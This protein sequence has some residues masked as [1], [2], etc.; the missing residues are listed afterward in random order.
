[1]EGW[2]S[3]RGNKP[4]WVMTIF[5]LVLNCSMAVVNTTAVVSMKDELNMPSSTV[6]AIMSFAGIGGL[7]ASFFV[8]KFRQRLGLGIIFGM[9]ALIH[10]LGY[11]GMFI[12][13]QITI[14]SISLFVI[15][16]VTTLYTVS[17]YTFRLEH[18]PPEMIGRISG[19]TGTLFRLGMPV[20]MYFSGW[21]VNWWGADSVFLSSAILNSI[22]FLILMRTMIWKMK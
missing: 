14:L 22:V 17:A 7:V 13:N 2:L 11:M 9:S 19:I 16:F 18:T 20:T 21:M 8:N 3:F 5:I 1:M 6:A 12:S 4:L 15:G 10:A